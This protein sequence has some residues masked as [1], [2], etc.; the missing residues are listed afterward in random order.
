VQESGALEGG[1]CT[2]DAIGYTPLG[3]PRRQRGGR[4]RRGRK[5]LVGL[6]DFAVSSPTPAG[7]SNQQVKHFNTLRAITVSMHRGA[8]VR[9]SVREAGKD[10]G[11]SMLLL[12]FAIGP[13]VEIAGVPEYRQTTAKELISPWRYS[14]CRH[15]SCGV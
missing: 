3:L 6:S 11:Q 13:T 12:L 10:R 1:I 9:G 8:G 15:L 4:P 2:N 14:G 7:A 5:W